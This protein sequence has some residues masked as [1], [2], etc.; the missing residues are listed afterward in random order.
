[1][2]FLNADSAGGYPGVPGRGREGQGE[3]Q[4]TPLQFFKFI[5]NN[6]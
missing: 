1:M 3:V 4:P 5:G 2:A 6:F